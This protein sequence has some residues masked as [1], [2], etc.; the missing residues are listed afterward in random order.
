MK[1]GSA[2]KW[3]ELIKE[4][5]LSFDLGCLGD[6]DSLCT[7][8]VLCDFIHQGDYRLNTITGVREYAG[9]SFF[10]DKTTLQR[11]NMKSPYWSDPWRFHGPSHAGALVHLADT[12]HE[13]KVIDFIEKYY[14][15]L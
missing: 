9:S 3:V 7:F 5:T 13:K 11:C 14:Q 6:A 8:G 1:R 2:L 15:Y 4:R 12:T 10:P